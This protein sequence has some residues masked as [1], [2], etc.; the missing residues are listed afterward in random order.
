MRWG[1]EKGKVQSI[2]A[3]VIEAEIV[4]GEIGLA[5]GLRVVPFKCERTCF[6]SR[7]EDLRAK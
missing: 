5:G 3:D 1:S 7:V 2:S 6:A 4:S